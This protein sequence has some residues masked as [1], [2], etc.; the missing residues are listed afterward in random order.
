LAEARREHLPA[1]IPDR[2]IWTDSHRV[3]HTAINHTTDTI[4]AACAA[5]DSI[6]KE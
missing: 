2:C 4:L 1:Y 5:V 3:M 6:S